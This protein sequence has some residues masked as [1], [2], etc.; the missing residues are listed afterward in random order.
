MS[1]YDKK[2]ENTKA[3]ANY[4]EHF[5]GLFIKFINIEVNK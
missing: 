4:T 2:N 3:C 5:F 1:L